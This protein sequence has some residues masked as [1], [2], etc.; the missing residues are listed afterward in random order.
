MNLCFN[1]ALS[2]RKLLLLSCKVQYKQAVIQKVN[3]LQNNNYFSLNFCCIT[4]ETSS[5]VSELMWQKRNLQWSTYI[6]GEMTVKH[7]Q[8][9][10]RHDGTNVGIL[11]KYKN[12]LQCL[13]KS[14]S[15]VTKMTQKNWHNLI[16]QNWEMN[17]NVQE[18]HGQDDV[19]RT[20]LFTVC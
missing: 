1:K 4:H 9:T 2:E 18:K 5:Y 10:K 17:I 3:W 13:H 12:I 19:T 11:T 14:H 15:T 8:F 16:R 6:H 7:V 20:P